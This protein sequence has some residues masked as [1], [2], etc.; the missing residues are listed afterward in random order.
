MAKKAKLSATVKISPK[1]E[2]ITN[3]EY[4]RSYIFSSGCSSPQK[5]DDGNVEC[6]YLIK[7]YN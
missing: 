7:T 5:Y 4:L 6:S 1:D 2:L 3:R